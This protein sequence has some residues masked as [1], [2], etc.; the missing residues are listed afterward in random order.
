MPP[1]TLRPAEQPFDVEREKLKIEDKK[2]ALEREKIRLERY[3]TRWTAISVVVPLVVAVI[4]LGV[5]VWNQN[6]QMQSQFAIASDQARAQFDMQRQQAA[7]QA[8]LQREQA[9]AQFEMKA[10][11]IVMGSP[12]PRGAHTKA[13][14]MSNLFPGRLPSNFADSFDP[15]Q[16]SAAPAESRPNDV[17]AGVRGKD[18]RPA[19]RQWLGRPPIRRGTPRRV[20]AIPAGEPTRVPG[21]ASGTPAS[22]TNA[23]AATP[24]AGV[25]SSN[26]NEAGTNAR[27]WRGRGRGRRT[28]RGRRGARATNAAPDAWALPPAQPRRRQP[29]RQ[30]RGTRRS[31]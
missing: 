11:E 26:T 5:S 9:K 3:K 15:D 1:E 17:A 2:I 16:Y 21:P 25:A 7:L 12:T 22:G 6:R 8:D 23:N 24:P 19:P 28:W 10:A 31:G 27:P 20:S 18:A 13:K 4:T 30:A 14:A 29:S